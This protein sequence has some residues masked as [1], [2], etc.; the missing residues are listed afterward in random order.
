MPTYR[1]VGARL[2]N[3][4][5]TAVVSALADVGAPREC[6]THETRFP[7]VIGDGVGIREFARV[8]AGCVRSTPVGEQS[9]LMS[10]N[11]VAHD[12]VLGRGV[13]IG[14]NA[15]LGGLSEVGDGSLIGARVVVLPHR[16]IGRHCVVE[17]GSVVTHDIPDFQRWAGNPARPC[18]ESRPEA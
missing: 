4:A 11:Y 2:A 16:K 15:A 8:H 9:L 13:Q 5:A 10:G 3:V 18:G 14:P 7:A 1:E 12:V 6:V 17:P